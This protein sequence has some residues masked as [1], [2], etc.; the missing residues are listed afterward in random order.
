M[1]NA[2]TNAFPQN[3]CPCRA[4]TIPL[5]KTLAHSTPLT[6]K[7]NILAPAQKD[8][9]GHTQP[10]G[11]DCGNATSIG[12]TH[13]VC[14]NTASPRPLAHTHNNNTKPKNY[15]FQI[16]SIPSISD[17]AFELS[18]CFMEF[19][20]QQQWVGLNRIGRAIGNPDQTDPQ[21]SHLCTT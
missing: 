13:S 18:Q 3:P 17:H 19:T 8:H 14:V 20:P 11:Y 15:N 12:S 4:R 7:F 9:H 1:F 2:L 10:R 16:E 6:K 5:H 21:L